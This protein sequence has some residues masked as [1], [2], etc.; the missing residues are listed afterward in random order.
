MKK[1]FVSMGGNTDTLYGLSGLGDLIGTCTSD[2]SRNRWAGIQI[3][4][5]QSIE[6]I[7][8]IK[9]I[10]VE[11]ISSLSAVMEMA[12]K[13]NVELPICNEVYEI[14]HNKKNVKK[15]IKDLM[16]RDLKKEF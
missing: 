14:V 1:I 16:L 13:L 12:K 2:L 10:T 4:K 11:G 15:S 5:G 3:A 8:E 7:V 9:K 6:E